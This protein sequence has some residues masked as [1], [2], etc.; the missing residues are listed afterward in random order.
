[1]AP[2]W[3]T[4][5]AAALLLTAAAVLVILINAAFQDGDPAHNR[6]IALR[7]A[8]LIAAVILIPLVL[9]ATHALW[10]RVAQ[11]GWTV[12]RIATA[13][14]LVIALCY[15]FGY[16]LAALLSLRGGVWM[17]LVARVNVVTAFV[18]LAILL[19][20]FT[21]LGDPARLAVN[22]QLA[23]LKGGKVNPA[24]FDFQYLRNEGGRYG[25][26]ALNDLSKAQF[27]GATDTIRKMAAAALAGNPIPVGKATKSDIAHN[28]TV[29]PKGRSLP[30]T[31]LSQDWS[32][33]PNA[34]PCLTQPVTACDGF[35]GDFDGDGAEEIA[36]V[37]GV[38]PFWYGTVMKEGPDKQWKPVASVS[39]RC[40]GMLDALK[41]GQGTVALP[42]TVWRDWVVRGIHLQV[43]P[44]VFDTTPCPT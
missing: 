7:Y 40:T 35:F 41:K 8:E 32:L 2:L 6:P 29:Y 21:P 30:A 18:V 43:S 11:Y 10:L 26:L 42:A 19:A 9:I 3:A 14:T 13:A 44:L 38:D 33:A 27:G 36:L 20:M 12:E 5:S 37:S 16:G 39:G 34:P 24:A 25:R 15:A 28:V 31:M 23:R 1:L 4:K 17:H 22:S